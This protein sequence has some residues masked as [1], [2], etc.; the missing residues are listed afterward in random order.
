MNIPNIIKINKIYQL[1]EKNVKKINT[2]LSPIF[3]YI[4]PIGTQIRIITIVRELH[5]IK[6]YQFLLESTR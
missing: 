2:F 6:M 5:G 1:G 4:R 3:I